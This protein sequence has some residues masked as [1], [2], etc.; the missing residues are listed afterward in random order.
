[1]S[2]SDETTICKFRHLPE[3]RNL[4]SRLFALITEYLQENGLK[5]STG[6]MVD[7]TIIS[8]PNSTKNRDQEVSYRPCTPRPVLAAGV[9]DSKN[10]PA[11]IR[12]LCIETSL[13][14]RRR[15]S[16]GSKKSIAGCSRMDG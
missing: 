4:G 5:V 16:C 3:R 1:M 6:T 7:A 11:Y 8:A 13:C 14:H 15:T 9:A 2:D 10:N 12:L